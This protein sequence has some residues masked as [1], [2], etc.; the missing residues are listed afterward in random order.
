M[1]KVIHV[2]KVAGAVLWRKGGCFGEDAILMT[3]CNTIPAPIL[4]LLTGV[5]GDP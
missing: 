4:P 1:S 2:L 5:Q 3:I